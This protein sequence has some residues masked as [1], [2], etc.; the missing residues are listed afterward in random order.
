VLNEF[1]LRVAAGY[2][3]NQPKYGQK[4]TEL[5]AGNVA[6]VPTA[7]LNLAG[8]GGGTA[9][10]GAPDI[11]PERQQE[12]EGGFD[13]T[14][15]HSRGNLEFT[16]YQKTISDLLLTRT[17]A[18][19]TGFGIQIFNGGQLR[20]RGLES[21]LNYYVVQSSALQWNVRGTFFLSRCTIQSLP[22]PAFRPISFLNSSTFGSTFI[23]E[24]KSC[25]QLTGND[26]TGGTGATQA[27]GT[28]IQN[29]PLTDANPDYRWSFGNDVTYKRF[30]FYFLVDR[31]KGGAL[32]N[33]T[34]LLYDLTGTSPDQTS[35]TA[36]GSCAAA[37]LCGGWKTASS[38][39]GAGLTGDQRADMFNRGKTG[40]FLE[41]K[42][43][44][45]L[46]E[47]TISYEVPSNVV[48]KIWSGARFVRIGLSGRNLLTV[49]PFRGA[50][51]ENNEIQRSAA[52]GVP[53]EIWAYPPSRSMWFN[54]DLGF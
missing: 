44:Y 47:V 25:T 18:P 29:V 13:A 38:G 16:L 42:S 10:T 9:L 31:E 36:Q 27:G 22:V 14:L 4:F 7:R 24:G 53:W 33:A 32:L 54:V 19:T 40:L 8:G 41:D 37:H 48:R 23:Q 21:S 5:V 6:G 12:L 28:R 1:K 52:E 45:K 11:K 50:D 39:I 51:P 43:Y 17:L 3:G 30:R 20:T 34:G 2:S 46:R 26:I 15:F 35:A 49:T